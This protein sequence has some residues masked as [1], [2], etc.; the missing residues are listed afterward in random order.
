MT[1]SIPSNGLPFTLIVGI[2]TNK[3]ETICIT[4]KD[5]HK[6]NTFYISRKGLVNGYKEYELKFPQTPK[7]LVFSIYNFDKPNQVNNNNDNSFKVTKFEANDCKTYPLWSDSE[8]SS[9]V[10][11]AKEFSANASILSAGDYKPSIYRS[12]DGKFCI[13]YYNKIRNRRNGKFVSTPARIGHNTGIIEISKKDFEKYTLPMRMVILLH[14]FSHKYMN[15]KTN[16]DISDEVAADINALNIYLSLGYPDIEAQYAFLKVFKGAN[17]ELN[18]KR[19][20]ILDDFI[21]KFSTGQL[22]N[23]DTVKETKIKKA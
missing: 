4:A 3:P 15:P 8:V 22:E 12:D 19:Y 10:K 18:K 20:L 11:F 9:F 17:N 7:L 14:E 21:K 2:K 5:Y 16:R 1:F 13:D 23:I 6:P